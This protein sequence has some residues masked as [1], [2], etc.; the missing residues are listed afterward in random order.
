[1]DGGLFVMVS[2]SVDCPS[3]QPPGRCIRGQTFA[4]HFCLEPRGST[5]C[6]LTHVSQADLRYLL[7][8]SVVDYYEMSV[9]SIILYR[10][11]HLRATERVY[12]VLPAT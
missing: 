10:I 1:M 8:L 6:R 12:T 9:K 5:S 4:S 7:Q 3:V 11:T 2:V